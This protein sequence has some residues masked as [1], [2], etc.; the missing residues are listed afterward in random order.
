LRPQWLGTSLRDAFISQPEADSFLHGRKPGGFGGK[1]QVNLGGRL[2]NIETLYTQRLTL[3][4]FT[5]ADAEDIFA[6]VSDERVTMFLGWQPHES[7]EETRQVLAEW[8][9][10]H[11][12]EDSFSW[13]IEFGGRVIGR[14]QTD[15]VSGRHR[16]CEVG[17]YI[18][19]DY[20][21]MGLMTEAL[22]RVLDYFFTQENFNR[23]EAIFEPDN[24]ASGR[25]MQK[26]GMKYEGTLRQFFL[27]RDG[28]Y[29]DGLLCAILKE[30]F[31]I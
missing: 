14:I 10:V 29:T 12:D 25:V 13:A 4:A 24:P 19:H 17:Y 7:I 8:I 28:S 20:W 3:R 30:E 5:E 18:G 11:T 31:N 16:R 23:V 21:N 9:S 22:R 26:C 27:C 15:Y 1:R 6:W 2:F